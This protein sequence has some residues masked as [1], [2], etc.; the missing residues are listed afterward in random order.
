MV[1]FGVMYEVVFFYEFWVGV[2]WVF[3]DYLL[4]YW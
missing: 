1:C 2:D 3:V 4:Y